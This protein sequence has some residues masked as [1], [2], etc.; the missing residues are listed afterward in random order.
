MLPGIQITK[1]REIHRFKQQLFHSFK[2]IY[3]NTNT[4]KEGER[5]THNPFIKS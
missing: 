4:D 5:S 2:Y 3:T 1:E